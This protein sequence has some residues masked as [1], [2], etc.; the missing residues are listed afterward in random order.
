M[1]DRHL[2]GLREEFGA[3]LGGG[4]DD[5]SVLDRLANSISSLLVRGVRA[6]AWHDAMRV[7]EDKDPEAARTEMLR[8]LDLEASVLGRVLLSPLL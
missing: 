2:D 8:D 7:W 6:N 3:P 1:F 4:D 5:G